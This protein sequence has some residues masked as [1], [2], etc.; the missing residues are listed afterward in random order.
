MKSPSMCSITMDNNEKKKTAEFEKEDPSHPLRKDQLH[1]K[2]LEFHKSNILHSH[3]LV[4]ED[5]KFGIAKRGVFNKHLDHFQSSS[6]LQRLYLG[7]KFI[8]SSVM[9]DSNGTFQNPFN[10]Y[11]LP[12][13]SSK[14]VIPPQTIIYYPGNIFECEG[15]IKNVSSI[16]WKEHDIDMRNKESDHFHPRSKK[17]F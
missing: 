7:P 6:I 5:P 11:F 4:K 9:S 15:G 3:N 1:N 16:N 12:Y 13:L 2:P 8:T 17:L 10:K 14:H